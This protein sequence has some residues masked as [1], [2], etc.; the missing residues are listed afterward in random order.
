MAEV[1]EVEGRV[2]PPY[3][4]GKTAAEVD[5]VS[6]PPSMNF[7]TRF[8]HSLREPHEAKHER[9]KEHFAKA[10]AAAKFNRA[11]WTFPLQNENYHT[12]MFYNQHRL[13]TEAN[14]AARPRDGTVE[15][16]LQAY[17]K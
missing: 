3:A 11:Y 16:M 10:E 4:M 6:A 15:S 8:F 7:M 1:V 14:L 5:G 12:A 9:L 13:A 17:S 2:G